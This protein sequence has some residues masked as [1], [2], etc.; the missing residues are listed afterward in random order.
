[1][2]TLRMTM[3]FLACLVLVSEASRLKRPG[4]PS[5]ESRSIRRR[6]PKAWYDGK[7][8]NYHFGGYGACNQS[9]EPAGAPRRRRPA[10]PAQTA[11]SSPPPPTPL[12]RPARKPSA[13]SLKRLAKGAWQGANRVAHGVGDRIN[14]SRGITP[15]DSDPNS[16]GE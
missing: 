6:L 7:E 11:A 3:S 9:V 2:M 5:S 16:R 8:Y 14:R 1:M 12:P 13:F 10:A 15:L 4:S